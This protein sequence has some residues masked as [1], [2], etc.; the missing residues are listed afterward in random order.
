MFDDQASGFTSSWAT[1]N[2]QNSSSP[3]PPT[4]PTQQSDEDQSLPQEQEV[5]AIPANYELG[6]YLPKKFNIKIPTHN[7]QFDEQKFLTLLAGSISLMKDEKVKII[8]SIPTLT[9]NQINELMRIFEEERQQ[10]ANLSDKHVPELEKLSKLHYMDWMDIETQFNQATK[11][12]ED[13]QKAE[14]IRKQ[15]GLS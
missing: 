6:K 12:Q 11:Q 7:H 9:I 5:N 14:E 8:Q 10:F 2:T 3:T 4:P 15:L 1:G 13:Q